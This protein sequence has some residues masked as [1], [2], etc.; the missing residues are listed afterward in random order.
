MCFPK[1]E[2]LRFYGVFG[3][4]VQRLTIRMQGAHD[5]TDMGCPGRGKKNGRRTDMC[6]SLTCL[7]RRLVGR[8]TLLTDEQTDGRAERHSD[9][10]TH[11]CIVRLTDRQKQ[12]DRQAEKSSETCQETENAIGEIRICQIRHEKTVH[13]IFLP[14][15][16][17]LL[18]ASSSFLTA[19]T[20]KPHRRRARVSTCR[21]W[22]NTKPLSA[23]LVTADLQCNVHYHSL[24]SFV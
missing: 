8:Q 10:Q 7:Y 18:M 2:D 15:R 22:Q 20:W 21:T 23:L 5:Q 4:N 12:T 17:S 13:F 19:H 3:G 9:K 16:V 6:A 24:E 1:T 14:C 11:Q